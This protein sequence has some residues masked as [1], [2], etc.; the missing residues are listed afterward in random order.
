MRGGKIYNVCFSEGKA[1]QIAFRHYPQHYSGTGDLFTSVMT[2]CILKGKS[3]RRAVK[4]AGRFVK[5]AVGYSV[6]RNAEGTF[7]V[8]FE[9]FL[10]TLH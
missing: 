2:A 9:Q 7:G 10:H 4:T 8:D 1:F 5:R 3:L 6:A